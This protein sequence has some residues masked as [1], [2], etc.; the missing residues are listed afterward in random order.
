MTE[1]N[2]LNGNRFLFFFSRLLILA[3]MVLVFTS[4]FS[5]V[6]VFAMKWATGIDLIQ[7]TQA[8]DPATQTEQSRT[9]LLFF[10]AFAG[11]IGTFLIPALLFPN[12]I[13]RN[14]ILFIR[15]VQP[16]KMYYLLL[17][18]LMILVSMPFISWLNVLNQSFSFPEQF[19]AWEASLRAIED[20]AEAITKILIQSNSVPGFMLN[21]LV[22]AVLPAI[23]EEFFFR[24]V[25]QN[26]T[27]IC[28]YNNHVAI[29]F[30]AII[31]SGIHGQFY[32]F[33]P[34]MVLGAGLGYLYL[35]SGNIWVS[36]LAHF[37]NNA[38]ALSLFVLAQHYPEISFFK[39]DYQFPVVLTILS[40]L[41][42]ALFFYRQQKL[43]F[44]QL[45][46]E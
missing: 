11:S 32:G 22:V 33:I 13:R 46:D 20:Q 3:G 18:P 7:L 8:L 26:F 45:F 2:F 4:I 5:L 41:G 31:F 24:G 27:R 19:K 12:A 23:A 40:M 28:F 29:W 38:L 6:G 9:A 37:I 43:Q 1:T 42:I 14:A 25:L 16:F 36:V 35:Y 21:L 44:R 17:A 10:Q 34:R 39:D 15:I 30:S